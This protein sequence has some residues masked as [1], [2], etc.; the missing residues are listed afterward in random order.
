MSEI[1][2]DTSGLMHTRTKSELT[3]S[4][5]CVY[6][7]LLSVGDVQLWWKRYGEA[8][9]ERV[10]DS[11]GDIYE[12][13]SGGEHFWK[14]VGYDLTDDNEE[15]LEGDDEDF[16]EDGFEDDDD[17]DLEDLEHHEDAQDLR[18]YE[19]GLFEYLVGMYAEMYAR[20]IRFAGELADIVGSIEAGDDSMEVIDLT[21]DDLDVE[22]EN[23]TEHIVDLTGDDE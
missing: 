3:R 19:D 14:R 15:V 18:D 23:A 2:L 20:Q 7:D 9:K 22:M 13:R 4:A 8:Y 10:S 11:E 21:G 17:E 6:E 16:D 1:L 5:S 12:M